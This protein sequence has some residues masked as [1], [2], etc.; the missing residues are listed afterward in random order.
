[1]K[2]A[3]GRSFGTALAAVAI[4]MAGCDAEPAA[5]PPAATP[6]ATTPSHL[7]GLDVAPGDPNPVTPPPCS[8]DGISVTAREPDAA[9]GLRAMA[10][11][12]L[13]CGKKPYRLNGYPALR[14]LD[15]NRQPFDVKIVRGPTE[16]KDPGPK[17]LTLR[18][19][20]SAQ[21]IVVWRNTVTYTETTAVKGTYLELVPS[22]GRPPQ[23]V[24]PNGSLDLGTTALLKTTAWSPTTAR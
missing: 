17:P 9:M 11:T 10:V 5:A 14:V 8:P 16:V 23:T 3:R 22:P 7:L 12:L 24:R 6:S 13:N 19:G 21:V 15:E 4:M 2:H 20:R 1:M 18:P